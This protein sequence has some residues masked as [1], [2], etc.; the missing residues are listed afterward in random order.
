MK[1]EPPKRL[2]APRP[3]VVA[4]ERFIDAIAMGKIPAYTLLTGKSS[5]NV[6]IIA[7]NA[8]RNP[9][10]RFSHQLFVKVKNYRKTKVRVNLLVS[11][12]SVPGLSPPVS[13]LTTRLPSRTMRVTGAPVT[14]SP[15]I[16]R[17]LAA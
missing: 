8:R 1:P 17:I 15:P 2:K 4:A 13:R 7:F 16:S 12:G 10:D 11:T 6:G 14:T 5:N 9:A 3:E